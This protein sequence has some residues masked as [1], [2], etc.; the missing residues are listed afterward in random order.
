MSG[1]NSTPYVTIGS[2][3]NCQCPKC[4]Y[5]GPTKTPEAVM[6]GV[7]KRQEYLIR[8]RFLQLKG[9]RKGALT[10]D[11]VPDVLK[12]GN[13]ERYLAHYLARGLGGR[14]NE[15]ILPLDIIS[16][17]LP[18]TPR[19][20]ILSSP[21]Q[22][23]HCNRLNAVLSNVNAN[24]AAN[25]NVT[26]NVRFENNSLPV[27]MPMNVNHP[28][29]YNMPNASVPVYS[30]PAEVPTASTSNF[31][32]INPTA[33]V[34]VP[35]TTVAVNVSN[36]DYF[37]PSFVQTAPSMPQNQSNVTVT[38]SSQNHNFPTGP[39]PPLYCNMPPPNSVPF[40]SVPL[41][42]VPG[43]ATPVRNNLSRV[44][45]NPS[46]IPSV[47][48]VGSESTVPILNQTA[49]DT[50]ALM[51]PAIA[52]VQY[53]EI[54]PPQRVSY[55]S[56]FDTIPAQAVPDLRSSHGA[57]VPLVYQYDLPTYANVINHGSNSS[58]HSKI[59]MRPMMTDLRH[60]PQT[61]TG[62]PKKPVT[63]R[64]YYTKDFKP[65]KVQTGPHPAQV[66]V[67]ISENNSE[68]DEGWIKT[69][70]KRKSDSEYKPP[71]LP[72][73]NKFDYYNK[74]KKQRSNLV[75]VPT[76][77]TLS[78]QPSTLL[79]Q[80]I[81]SQASTST[82][83]KQ[84]PTFPHL[85]TAASWEQFKINHN[86]D[87]SKKAAAKFVH[88]L[89][90]VTQQR[91]R[92]KMDDPERHTRILNADLLLSLNLPHV[93]QEGQVNTLVSYMDENNDVFTVKNK[94]DVNN[95]HIKAVVQK[96]SPTFMIGGVF[97]R[98]SIVKTH[99]QYENAVK[100]INLATE[101]DKRVF[102]ETE[103]YD[104]HGNTDCGFDHS[105]G[106]TQLQSHISLVV[107][108]V[109][110]RAFIF[111]VFGKENANVIFHVYGLKSLFE[112]FEIQ[113]WFRDFHGNFRSLL[114]DCN[115]NVVNGHDIQL[116]FLEFILFMTGVNFDCLHEPNARPSLN[117][118]LQC[119]DLPINDINM[120]SD[121]DDSTIRHEFLKLHDF[122]SQKII[123]TGLTAY[124]RTTHV[125]KNVLVLPTLLNKLE[126]CLQGEP[127]IE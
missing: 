12:S 108:A 70:G 36:I 45:V 33:P 111:D 7:Q 3:L 110:N 31:H 100:Q 50:G 74:R 48:T 126:N 124:I 123:R 5:K 54:P 99:E 82:S 69:Q 125:V 21:R 77:E 75:N 85:P 112:N 103:F 22:P 96:P 122:L 71:Q 107:I 106:I 35:P 88:N 15:P 78:R 115:V 109:A 90:G 62:T 23:V 43:I 95:I 119:F 19:P 44:S 16:Q 18:F 9:Y 64:S 14:P 60:R 6:K 67:P 79:N 57:Q 32:V 120:P 39:P 52:T 2:C 24:L 49:W 30:M 59:P 80:N 61:Q 91:I 25:M 4:K 27:S 66:Q 26:R 56:V 37:L 116:R 86:N 47:A 41:S 28:V 65:P 81:S 58:P 117:F 17:P 63:G 29:N 93:P 76:T 114:D 104:C 113:K 72:I 118:M 98:V 53:P 1:V 8:K 42:H 55:R 83:V 10:P 89:A 51:D 127:M 102:V 92:N 38:S 34:F 105:C 20:N 94:P 84:N 121:W 68:V 97:G 11:K 40:L 87:I 13:F 73:S 101:K 46:Q